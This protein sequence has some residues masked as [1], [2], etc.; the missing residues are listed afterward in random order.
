APEI[1]LAT[2]SCGLTVLPVCPTWKQCG[3]QPE[4]TAAREAP[5]AAPSA[6]AS[7]STAEKSPPVPR[8]PDTTMAASV[9]SGRPVASLGFESTMRS[10]W[11]ASEMSALISS[12]VPAP[13]T[14]SGA[15]EFGLTAITGIPLVIVLSTVWLPANT[16]WVVM[17]DPD[18]TRT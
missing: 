5:T 18:S 16:D 8:P 12:T 4:S 10:D 14:A 13:D 9:S 15:A 7:P 6:S 3:Y 2:Y 1:P 17:T 11:A